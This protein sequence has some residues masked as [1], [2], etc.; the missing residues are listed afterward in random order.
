MSDYR[1]GL[2]GGDER[3]WECRSAAMALVYERA[4]F[5]GVADSNGDRAASVARDLGIP[6]SYD[7]IEKL[8]D[9]GLFGLVVTSPASV[10]LRQV[11]Y[12]L[13]HD[14]HVFCDRPY[15]NLSEVTREMIR[16]ARQRGRVLAFAQPLARQIEASR[17]LVRSG[18]IGTPSMLMAEWQR[19]ARAYDRG[20]PSS[21]TVWHGNGR[22]VGADLGCPLVLAAAPMLGA[23]VARVSARAWWNRGQHELGCDSGVEDMMHILVDCANGARGSFLVGWG[24][25]LEEDVF[26]IRAQGSGGTQLVPLM[27]TELDP[28]R[29]RPTMID[30]D[31]E[32][33]LGS[34]PVPP[35]EALADGLLNW[36]QAC[37]GEAEL[38]SSS[39]DVADA[40]RVIDAAYESLRANGDLVTIARS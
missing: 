40:M 37:R 5:T 30:P 32:P 4:R 27:A 38:I 14:V 22:G 2:V 23:P 18:R 20:M 12:A 36:L 28:E 33:H 34:P 31:C 6:N 17:A 1:L 9:T 15:G 8:V 3:G 29:F 39:E 16:K 13:D 10:S 24:S 26:C 7:S 21:A 19:S 25:L 35:A 11:N